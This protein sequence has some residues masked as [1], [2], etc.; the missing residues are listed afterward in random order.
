MEPIFFETTS[1]FR[2]WLDKNH[3]S[4]KEL[5]VGFYKVA[6]GK[7]SMSWSGSVDE[8]LCFGWIDGVRK[9][10]DS[11]SYSIRFT[12]RKPSSIWSA[13]NIKKVEQLIKSKLIKPEG[14]QAF[15]LRSEAKSSIYSH[16]N[17]TAKLDEKL[18]S[19]FRKNKV[20]WN[21]FNAQPPGYKKVI[22]HWITSAK[23]EKTK[24]SRLEKV[25]RESENGKRLQ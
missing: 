24:E 8:A 16:E 22:L 25:I 2:N 1:D 13:V 21:F 10:I 4:K 9:S 5:L 23:Q 15:A 14:L 6:S 7:P 12:P 17:P 18:E 19:E 3:D 20:A 11:E